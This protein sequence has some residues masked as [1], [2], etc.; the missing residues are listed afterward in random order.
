M[1]SI[2]GPI[3]STVQ[4]A[5]GSLATWNTLPFKILGWKENT[6]LLYRNL[7]LF[8]VHKWSSFPPVA[9][10]IFFFWDRVAWILNCP[11]T[12][13]VAKDSLKLLVLLIYLLKEITSEYPI[14]FPVSC[15]VLK[16]FIYPPLIRCIGAT[17]KG[18]Y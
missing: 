15:V 4:E 11:Q 10:V 5:S 1:M 18:M 13:C 6:C 12:C 3:L 2:S 16:V 17:F 14:S 7:T 8:P 9:W